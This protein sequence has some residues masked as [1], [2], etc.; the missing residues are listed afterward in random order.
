LPSS[1]KPPSNGE[2]VAVWLAVGVMFALLVGTA[3]GFLGWLCSHS[4]AAALLTAGAAFGSA[5][6]LMILVIQLLRR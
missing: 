1:S 6:T 4:L 2:L 5:L 3:A